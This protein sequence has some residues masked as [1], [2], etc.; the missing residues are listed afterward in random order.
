MRAAEVI[1]AGGI[2]AYPTEAV[3]GLGCDPA[4]AEAVRKILQLKRR[5]QSAGVIL[6]AA[7]LD[8]LRG[9]IDPDDAEA[10]RLAS[11]EEGVTWVVKAGARAPEWVTGGRETIAVRITTHPT[12]AALCRAAGLPTKT[13]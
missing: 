9:W 4:N 6:I 5:A 1:R 7:D 3:Y 13:R 11:G 12:A 10:S 2:V 8:Q